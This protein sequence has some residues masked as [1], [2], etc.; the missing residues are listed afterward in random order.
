[1]LT[2]LYLFNGRGCAANACAVPV[3]AK[4]GSLIFW[5]KLTTVAACANIVTANHRGSSDEDD[6]FLKTQSPFFNVKRP[7]GKQRIS[8]YPCGW[9]NGI[10]DGP[11]LAYEEAIPNGSAHDF[12]ALCRGFHA[13]LDCYLDW[14]RYSFRQSRQL[15]KGFFTLDMGSSSFRT[16]WKHVMSILLLIAVHCG[17][18]GLGNCGYLSCC[19]H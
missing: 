3:K 2:W 18:R 19:D 15:K 9:I 13:S 5:S 4:C 14:V 1:M 16:M 12:P 10:L 6:V 7:D 11:G 8:M 17:R